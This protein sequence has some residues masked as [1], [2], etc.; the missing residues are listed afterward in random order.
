[1]IARLS[2]SV[3][4]VRPDPA[5][6]ENPLER[7]RRQHRKEIEGGSRM[8]PR[9]RKRSMS[10]CRQ[11]QEDPRPC[12]AGRADRTLECG[13]RGADISFVTAQEVPETEE[14]QMSRSEL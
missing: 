9:D 11:G 14:E 8:R 12:G 10:Q 2:T 6:A 13:D 5:R 3:P 7:G 1:M 4:S